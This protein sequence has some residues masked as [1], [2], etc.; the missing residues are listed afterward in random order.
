MQDL[1]DRHMLEL[2]MAG[3]SQRT[4]SGYRI[5][6]EQFM[7][8]LLS[9]FGSAEPSHINKA[10]IRAFLQWLSEKKDCNR[11]IARKMAALQS[12]FTFLKINGLRADNPMKNLRRP[13][14]EK[15]LPHFFTEAE[16]TTL[17]RIP[18]TSTIYGVRNRAIFEVLYSC[19]LRLEELANLQ[20]SDIDYRK[21]LLKVTGK[22]N[23][24]R[25]VPIGKP[26]LEATQEYLKLRPNLATEQ[27]SSRIFLTRTGK[28][29]DTQQLKIILG[30]YIDLIAREKGYS[31]HSIRHSFATHLLDRG[32]S[33]EAIQALLGH[34]N[35]ATT[36]KY[37]HVSLQDIKAAYEKG[38]PRSGK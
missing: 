1:I 26:A 33:L 13:K 6:L 21:G 11:T 36:E 7:S 2:A 23:K 29:F 34:S 16:M 14:F 12:W 5:D 18:D 38:H 37:T 17:I 24:Q 22:G 10:Q 25:I 8:F 9:H 19:G 28:D 27:S 35:L 32:A 20:L 31:A 15:K 4:V 3:K 30:G